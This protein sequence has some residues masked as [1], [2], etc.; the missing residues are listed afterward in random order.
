MEFLVILAILTYFICLVEIHADLEHIVRELKR[1]NDL[2][3]NNKG[4]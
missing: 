1:A 4:D 3:E 2:A